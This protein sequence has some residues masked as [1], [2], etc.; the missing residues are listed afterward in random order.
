MGFVCAIRRWQCGDELPPTGLDSRWR[1]CDDRYFRAIQTMVSRSRAGQLSA[2]LW[3]DRAVVVPHGSDPS[4]T[5]VALATWVQIGSFGAVRRVSRR[6]L[7]FCVFGGV[8]W[9]RRL[10]LLR[11]CQ[12]FRFVFPCPPKRRRRVPHQ[13][14]WVEIRGFESR[15]HFYERDV[16]AQ[17]RTRTIG[18]LR[19][20]ISHE[21]E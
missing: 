1:C 18:A 20:E 11:V 7:S 4:Q 16:F 5:A 21:V 2:V 12:G 19:W 9:R 15:L 8:S 10:F 3:F 17:T 6:Y 13:T 14:I